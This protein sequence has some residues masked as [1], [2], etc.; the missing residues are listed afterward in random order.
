MT[1]NAPDRRPIA[2]ALVA[3]AG[4]VLA[5]TGAAL[6]WIEGSH[7]AATQIGLDYSSSQLPLQDG[8]S[9]LLLAVLSLVTTVVWLARDRVSP[10]VSAGIA[11]ALG[12]GAGLAALSG[13]VVASLSILNLRDIARVVDAA[14]AASP[15][16]ASIGVGIYLDL[17]AGLVMIAG[18]GMRLVL[19]REM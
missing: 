6:P 17:V 12:S 14:N 19:S 11:R 5:A 9:F 4:C 2:G 15:G 16:V 10:R 8:A 13:F 18:G 7:G 3:G 1:V